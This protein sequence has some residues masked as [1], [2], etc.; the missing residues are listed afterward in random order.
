MKLL[1]CIFFSTNLY[2]QSFEFQKEIVIKQP[3]SGYIIDLTEDVYRKVKHDNLSDIR[4]SNASHDL[5]PMRLL[6]KN[7]SIDY[8]IS[9]TTLPLFKINS[10]QTE[11]ITSRQVRTT[12]SGISEDISIT[13][14]KSFLKYLKS[15]EV[16][17]DN[18]YYVDAES[19]KGK[20][21]YSLILD[22]Q[23]EE[24]GNRVFYVD[25]QASNDL[26]KWDSL[27]NRHKLMDIKI[28]DKHVL[29]N[30]IQIKNFNYSYYRL[31]FDEFP[32]MLLKKVSVDL[33]DQSILNQNESLFI[34]EFSTQVKNEISFETNGYFPIE[35][36]QLAFDQSNL[37]TKVMLYSKSRDKDKWR[38]VSQESLYSILF[39]GEELKNNTIQVN[40]STH[41]YWKLVFDE[42]VNNEIIKQIKLSWR[43]HQIQ[44]MAQGQEPFTLLLG[45]NKLS[46]SDT[47]WYNKLPAD[48]R[49]KLFSKNAYLSAELEQQSVQIN[50][51]P[52]SLFNESNQKQWL[53]WGLLALII[54]LLIGMATKLLREIKDK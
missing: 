8:Q 38:F 39:E 45:N 3:A 44:F 10:I 16:Q 34:S 26:Q 7:D 53:F 40:R 52:A 22:W 49:S 47:G 27:R 41:Q 46:A 11:H 19:L 17:A 15:E 51:S 21:I 2:A 30:Q 20:T 1:I 33:L 23:F 28:G 35:S 48:I 36:I 31:K 25:L 4:I 24:A 54:T 32:S 43:P 13:T 50:D 18:I 9:I 12:R 6:K 29:E 42:N 37:I 5:V 14:S